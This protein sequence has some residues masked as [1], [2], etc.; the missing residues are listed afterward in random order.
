MST[1]I[2]QIEARNI[3]TKQLKQLKKIPEEQS[4]EAEKKT[5]KTK[6]N[7]KL[8]NARKGKQKLA[9]V[10]LTLA[11]LIVQTLK[12]DLN[13]FYVLVIFMMSSE[14][15]MCLCGQMTNIQEFRRKNSR[16]PWKII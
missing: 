15:L 5:V 1:M 8:Y 10:I 6:E 9:N 11:P 7:F 4:H 13:H 14:C 12:V 3:S 16:N 2:F